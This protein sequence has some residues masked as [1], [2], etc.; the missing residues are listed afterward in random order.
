M[1]LAIISHTEHYRMPDGKIAGWGPTITEINHLARAFE[2]IYHL[3]FLY[4]DAPPE[5]AL[6]YLHSN[7][8][9]IPLKPMGGPKILDKAG[10]LFRIPEV[11]TKVRKVLKQADVFQFR[12]PTGM[13]VF[14][15]PYLT[16]TKKKGWYKYAGNWLQEQPPLGYR[17]QRRMLKNQR[18]PVTING[19]W[20]DQPK[21]CLS[22]E[23][24][25]LTEEERME[26]KLIVSEK[27]YRLPFTFCFAGRLEDAKGVQRILDAFARVENK[28]WI[29]AVHFAGDGEKLNAYRAQAEEMG[30]P[31][32]FHGFMSREQLFELYKKSDF[33]LL[34]SHA[35][36]GFPKVIAEAMNFGCI[37]VVSGVSS[38]GQY[39]DKN[40]GF[41]IEPCTAEKLKCILEEI[42]KAE[43]KELKKKALAA[44]ERVADFTF[45]HYLRRIKEII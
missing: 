25:C 5:S 34:P 1:K 7:I 20:P 24:P 13:G 10:M 43:E 2:E 26:G 19:S 21:H 40:N 8:H 33:F 3:A 41:L 29:K 35:S 16:L 14:L 39:V 15:I 22:F 31:A 32:V 37:P 42:S 45:E 30:L 36:E 18:R 28:T 4:D 12:A 23:N 27:T 17:F 9:F 11:I 38:I 6:P 44:H